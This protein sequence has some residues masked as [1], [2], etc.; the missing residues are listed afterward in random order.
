LSVYYSRLDARSENLFPAKVSLKSSSNSNALLRFATT[1]KLFKTMSETKRARIL[2]IEDESVLADSL[3]QHLCEENYQVDIADNSTRARELF[4][5]EIYDVVLLSLQLSD[6]DSFELIQCFK[7][8]SPVAEIIALTNYGTISRAIEAVK[9]GAFFFVEKPF[10]FA[11]LLPLIELALEHRALVAQNQ[12]FNQQLSTRNYYEEML[13]ASKQMQTVY[14]RIEAVAKTDSPVLITGES[15]TGKE[16]IANAIHSNSLRARKPFTK[17]NCAALPKEL[18]ES[19]LFGHSMDAHPLAHADKRGLVRYADSSSLLLDE[20][21]EV[22]LEIQSKILKFLEEK[23][24][25]RLGCDEVRSAD[26]RFIATTNRK[27]DEAI[28]EK[29]LREDL[30]YYLSTVTI[31]IPPLRERSDDIALLADNFL[32]TYAQKYERNVHYIS[33]ASYKLLFAHSWNGNIR[34]LRNVIERAVLLAKT[35]KIEPSDLPFEN[36]EQNR[37][38]YEIPA[39]LTLDQIEKLII[40]KTL[41]RTLGNKQAA[42]QILG[43]YRPRLYAKIKRH[44]IDL[45][46]LSIQE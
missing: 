21:S 13:G 34:E 46:K 42:A 5:N 28:S 6:V 37:D 23:T 43:I 45:K 10:D 26:V 31:H 30:L 15:G 1:P 35:D 36:Q 38:V 16:L 33:S 24:F 27:L 40:T 25:S 11:E 44:R 7:T 8:D 20:I 4:S 32:N 9:T 39:E 22:P 3:Y 17:V 29:L 18:F 19:E 41:Q 2:L 14:D 12:S